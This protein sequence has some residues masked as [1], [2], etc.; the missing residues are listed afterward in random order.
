MGFEVR[1]RAIE[2]SLASLLREYAQTF[3]I[4]YAILSKS[5]L[6][7]NFILIL[8]FVESD[9][10]GDRLSLILDFVT[11]LPPMPIDVYDF[12]TL[13]REFLMYSLRHG[14]VVYV[15]NYETYIRDLERLF[16]TS[17]S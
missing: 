11:L 5:P 2:L 14:K 15:G 13:P 6:S 1:L 3:G 12:D 10:F 16:G 4:A 8:R 17:S 7:R 9:R